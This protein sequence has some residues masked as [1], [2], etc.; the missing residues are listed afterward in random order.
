MTAFLGG[1]GVVNVFASERRWR[2]FQNTICVFLEPGRVYRGF[3]PG[4]MAFFWASFPLQ[5]T[6]IFGR[7]LPPIHVGSIH[8]SAFTGT[9]GSDLPRRTPWTEA[10]M[11]AQWIG[12]W[13]GRTEPWGGGRGLAGVEHE[14]LLLKRT[15]L[16]V[17]YGQERFASERSVR[18]AVPWPAPFA[19]NIA[20]LNI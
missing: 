14:P 17:V 10:T 12:P 2:I 3:F 20:T 4:P 16:P 8:P 6:R 1:F 9:D 15:L 13:S 18:G 5:K 19:A 11:A 7:S